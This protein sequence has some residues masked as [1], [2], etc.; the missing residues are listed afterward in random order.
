MSAGSICKDHGWGLKWPL[1]L[2]GVI[3]LVC[4]LAASSASGSVLELEFAAVT[5][6][7]CDCRKRKEQ[8]RLGTTFATFTQY[9]ANW[10]NVQFAKWAKLVKFKYISI[11]TF[12]GEKRHKMESITWEVIRLSGI[13]WTKPTVG[14]GIQAV[15]E[16]E[17]TALL[18]YIIYV[19]IWVLTR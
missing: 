3:S 16:V 15:S 18:I 8:Q 10:V 2:I 5:G 7:I 12:I 6:Q 4:N 13:S 9:T 14:S 1:D 17:R 19:Q 11:F